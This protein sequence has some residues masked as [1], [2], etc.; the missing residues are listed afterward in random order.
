[1]KKATLFFGVM[2]I[3]SAIFAQQAKKIPFGF[4][5]SLKSKKEAVSGDYKSFLPSKST[6]DIKGVVL[7]YEDFEDGAT[8]FPPTDWTATSST[9]STGVEEWHFVANYYD[10]NSPSPSN[11][12]NCAAIEYLTSVNQLDEILVSP[13]I[14]IP[15]TGNYDLEFDWMSSYYWHIDPNNNGDIMV[16]I[17]TDNGTTWSA[18]IWQEDNQTL[19]EASGVIYPWTTFEWNKSRIDISAYA[20]N[21]V[22]IAFHFVGLDAAFFYL[23]DVTVSERNQNDIEKNKIFAH[24]FYTNGGAYA[25]VPEEQIMGGMYGASFTNVGVAAQNNVSLNVKVNKNGTEI[26]NKYATEAFNS[27][28]NGMHDTIMMDGDSA[29]VPDGIGEY[30]AIISIVQNETDENP[31][32]NVGNAYM[33]ITGNTFARHYNVD[34]YLGP[35]TYEGGA[36]GDFFGSVFHFINEDTVYGIRVFID[37]TSVADGTIIGY[38][39]DDDLN[40]VLVTEEFDVAEEHIGT[41]IV[42]PFE[43]LTGED[44]ILSGDADYTVG[45]EIYCAPNDLFIGGD[46][47]TPYQYLNI[48]TAI[49]IGDEWFYTDM[50][51][52]IDLLMWGWDPTPIGEEVVVNRTP[53]YPNPALYEVYV[54]SAENSVIQIYNMQ[55]QLLNT[56]QSNS[57]LTRIDISHLKS[58]FYLIK[59]IRGN[60]MTPHSLI[61][62]D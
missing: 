25:K 41:W 38:I 39:L 32:N 55:G 23:D 53:M 59:E 14:T 3:A 35:T 15:A 33:E 56:Y 7:L 37:E 54:P 6:K 9:Q 57:E 18:P 20:G 24:Y 31:D 27:F 51:P 26:Y 61:V 46:K 60:E 28:T 17:S 44:L 2:L 11:A 1:M 4:E 42:L 47:S 19:V 50:Q 13:T 16:K 49:R 62:A 34:N 58:G 52:G 12:R 40:E 43:D 5:K 21:D 36:D 29:F 45:V 8:T 10:G 30:E 48:S 22:L